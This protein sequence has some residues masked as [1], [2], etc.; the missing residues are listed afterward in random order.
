MSRTSPQ[1]PGV[2]P[3]NGRLFIAFKV[4]GKGWRYRKTPFGRGEETQALEMRRRLQTQLRDEGSGAG[5]DELSVIRTV[6]DYF[7]VWTRKR[8]RASAPGTLRDAPK[9]EDLRL[10]GRIRPRAGAR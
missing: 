9:V 4:P 7:H 10:V 3:R 5:T 6:A 8:A 2:Y 1:F